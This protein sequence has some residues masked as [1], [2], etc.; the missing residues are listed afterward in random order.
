[1]KRSLSGVM[2]AALV[3]VFGIPGWAVAQNNRPATAAM[4]SV[5]SAT[6]VD[7][8]YNDVEVKWTIADVYATDCGTDTAAGEN[9]QACA[10]DETPL[11]HFVVYYSKASG[12][13]AANAESSHEQAAPRGTRME[14]MEGKATV[15]GLTPDT[16]YYFLVAA[17]NGGNGGI[18]ETHDT[19]LTAKT[20]PA[21]K[22]G[23][24][25]GI[26]VTPGAMKL[27]VVVGCGESG[28]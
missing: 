16:T 22:P 3:L 9:G 6:P 20:D 11:T 8:K 5:D 1:M 24:V 17:K 21:P 26:G 28:C 4:T 18:G 10:P 2:G 15:K 19:R 25:T 13:N 7:P 27:T 23:Q 14:A 12:F